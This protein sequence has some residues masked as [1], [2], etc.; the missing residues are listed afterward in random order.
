MDLH[1]TPGS[2]LVSVPQMLDPNFM[3]TVLLMCEHTSQGALGLVVNRAPAL[4]V[5]DLLPEHPKFAELDFPVHHG[6]PVGLDSLQFVH[7]TD[8]RIPGGIE[9]APDLYLGGDLDSLGTFLGQEQQPQH[10]VRLFLGYAG[11]AAGQ[12]EGEL[13]TGSWVPAPLDPK[14]LFSDEPA[15]DVWRQSLRSLGLEGEGLSQ[16]PPDVSWN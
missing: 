4:I 10:S 8:E 9:L 7:T 16:L 15:E 12:L 3:H 13:Q 1:V 14:L 5:R 2:F 11:W 6:G